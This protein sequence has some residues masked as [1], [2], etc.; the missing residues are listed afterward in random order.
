MIPPM[1]ELY[2]G[3]RTTREDVLPALRL[4]LSQHPTTAYKS[5]NTL[6]RCLWTM[7]Y[8][9]YRPHTFEVE[10]ALEALMIDAEV[11]A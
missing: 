4:L 11:A 3:E 9:P 5:A 10:V 8:L 6:A 2:L 7:R 1:E